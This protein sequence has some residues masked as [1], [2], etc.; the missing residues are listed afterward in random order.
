M[1]DMEILTAVTAVIAF[2]VAVLS[3]VDA[4][5]G[6][7]RRATATLVVALVAGATALCVLVSPSIRVGIVAGTLVMLV[8]QLA[9]AKSPYRARRV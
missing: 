4:G 9:P 2:G 3:V 8:S 7:P 5:R 6:H 1:I